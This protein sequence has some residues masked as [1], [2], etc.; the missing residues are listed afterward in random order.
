[1]AFIGGGGGT[2]STRAR[3]YVDLKDLS[4]RK[5]T[6]RPGDRPAAPASWRGCPARRSIFQADPGPARRRPLERRA[7]PVHAA[8]RQHRRA[9]RLGPA[10]LRRSCARCR[11]SSTS[12]AI[13]R[14]AGSQASLD[15][16]SRH[17]VA[18][19]HPS[20]K[21]DDTLYD[22]F[23]QRSVST[24][25]T[26]LNQYHVVLEVDPKFWQNPDS[27]KRH[28]RAR[29]NG[30]SRCRSSAFTHYAPTTAPL[31]VN[32]QGQFPAVTVS[33]NLPPGVALGDAVDAIEAARARDRP[34]AGHS[35]QLRRAPRRRIRTRSPASRS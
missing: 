18:A 9:Q 4:E 19:R 35:R 22:A 28:L 34:A 33:F 8:G 6:R 2:P 14:P 15:D 13:S 16:R 21:I 23:G 20:Q 25:F 30:G 5:L 27:L 10:G 11:S 1:M 29:R 3:M 26:P 32:H 17:G 24:M 7:V 12:T 31:Q